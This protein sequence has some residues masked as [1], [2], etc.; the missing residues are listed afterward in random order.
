MI[1]KGIFFIIFTITNLV[2]NVHTRENVQQ[3]KEIK[4]KP[5][6]FNFTDVILQSILFCGTDIVCDKSI[7]RSL[8]IPDN[9]NTPKKCPNCICYELCLLEA[10][11]FSFHCCPDFFFQYGYPQC[12]DL[13][14]IS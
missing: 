6:D 3:E 1:I 8:K 12:E 2:G 5:F 14:V 4:E 9:I 11:E 13:S 10:V 7:L